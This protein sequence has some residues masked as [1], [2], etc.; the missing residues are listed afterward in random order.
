MTKTNGPDSSIICILKFKNKQFSPFA[1]SCYLYLWEV[2]RNF[3]NKLCTLR[4][5]TIF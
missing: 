1:C 3:E 2:K 5:K 4:Y